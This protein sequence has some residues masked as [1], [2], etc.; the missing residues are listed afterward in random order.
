MGINIINASN[1]TVTIDE[2]SKKYEGNVSII[3]GQIF[4]DGKYIN[5]EN[6]SNK[7]TVII[8]IEGTV[9]KIENADEVNVTGSV[10]GNIICKNF[11]TIAGDCHG[12]IKS[13]N[14]TNVSG[15]CRGS[16]ISGNDTTIGKNCS[17]KINSG[18]KTY[19]GSNFK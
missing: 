18:N 16:V 10:N 2:I 15:N 12:N 4:V 13:G 8:N 19:V 3:N 17:G 1:C 11:V 5:S 14:N 6:I 7:A 9:E